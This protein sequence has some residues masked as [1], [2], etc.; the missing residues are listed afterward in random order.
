MKLA[1]FGAGTMGRG[2]AQVFAANGH[3]VLMYASSPASAQRHKDTLGK[4]ML[5]RVEKGK[6]TQ[7][8]MDA[9]M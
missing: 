7:E 5:K 1:L 2:I 8:A 4:S 3:T 9:L 6:M